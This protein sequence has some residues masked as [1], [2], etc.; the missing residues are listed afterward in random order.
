MSTPL[1]QHVHIS[2]KLHVNS[3]LSPVHILKVRQALFFAA[4]IQM[5]LN[6]AVTC[7]SRGITAPAQRG[8]KG[9]PNTTALQ[10]SWEWLPEATLVTTLSGDCKFPT[11][12]KS[13][14]QG[15]CLHGN[16]TVLIENIP[17]TVVYSTRWL[18][19]NW[20]KTERAASQPG[21]DNALQSAGEKDHQVKISNDFYF[22]SA[23]LKAD[24][25]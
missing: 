22:P 4:A 15:I 12:G 2:H 16:L 8:T 25:F 3:E 10:R 24:F 21:R 18:R 23:L 6:K 14:H 1:N 5:E 17:F 11:P 7:R 9:F 13:R 19:N 20:S